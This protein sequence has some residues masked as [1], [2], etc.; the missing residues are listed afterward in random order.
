MVL[1]EIIR[2]NIL[3]SKQK[4]ICQQCNC[5]TK[6]AK[7]LAKSIIDKYNW[8]N[9]YEYRNKNNYDTPGT[10]I[11]L[12]YSKKDP[13][14]ICFMSQYGPSKPNG[15]RSYYKGTYKDSYEERKKWFQD[16][17]DIL[18][19]NNYDVVAM[20]YGIGCG[21]AGGK[22]KDYKDMIEKCSTKIILYRL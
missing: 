15:V 3:N 9:P 7:G 19:S 2:D 1:L 4:Y 16:C 6:S 21:L 10:I 8:A 17:L 12:E 22:W 11:E 14:I 13:I 5:V 18:D 20:P